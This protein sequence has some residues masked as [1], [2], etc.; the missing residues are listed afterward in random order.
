MRDCKLGFGQ[1]NIQA[2]ADSY[3]TQLENEE[4]IFTQ[5]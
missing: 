1:M 4:H 5:V 2:Y 3:E